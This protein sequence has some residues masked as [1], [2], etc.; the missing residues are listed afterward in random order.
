MNLTLFAAQ[1]PMKQMGAAIQ[2]KPNLSAQSAPVAVTKAV[3]NDGCPGWKEKHSELAADETCLKAILIKNG[4]YKLMEE[5]MRLEKEIKAAQKKL[6]EVTEKMTFCICT[7]CGKVPIT[8]NKG[9]YC[10]ECY[11]RI[12]GPG[13]F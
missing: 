11:K 8:G 10:A 2:S 13:P 1:C 12:W 7:K 4:Q 6:E 9:F 3:D 5:A